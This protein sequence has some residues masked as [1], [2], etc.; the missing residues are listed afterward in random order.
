MPEA[1]LLSL[2]AFWT[3]LQSG[4]YMPDFVSINAKTARLASHISLEGER[5]KLVD[6]V[7]DHI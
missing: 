4:N 5:A 1:L 2:L 7:E 6:H 3:D